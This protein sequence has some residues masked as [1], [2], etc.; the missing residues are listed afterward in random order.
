[1]NKTLYFPPQ[2]ASVFD[3]AAAIAADLGMI[4]K[5][6]KGSVTQL[7]ASIACGEA[8]VWLYPHPD[9]LHL[10]AEALRA[11]SSYD[12]DS[13]A[14]LAAVLEDTAARY[15]RFEAEADADDYAE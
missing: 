13:M 14:E 12:S 8:A 15:Y 2:D 5:H 1:M 4:G 3:D 9:S 6:G 11:A 10:A 7:L